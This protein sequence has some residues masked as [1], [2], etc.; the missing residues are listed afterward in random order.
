MKPAT[1]V[2]SRRKERHGAHRNNQRQNNFR[3]LIP[4]LPVIYPS[5]SPEYLPLVNSVQV[6]KDAISI[7]LVAHYGRGGNFIIDNNY[8]I[9]PRLTE[10]A[11]AYDKRDM[12]SV[13]EWEVYKAQHIE[14]AKET[15][16][17]EDDRVSWYAIIMGI[18]TKTLYYFGK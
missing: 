1:K 4:E 2:S 18:A 7:Y 10:P 11:T 8:F 3:G 15:K 17:L 16:R 5:N 13:I 9:P 12:T 6:F 14:L